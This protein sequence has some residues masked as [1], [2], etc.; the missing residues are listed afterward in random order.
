MMPHRKFSRMHT[1]FSM[2]LAR[3]VWLVSNEGSSKGE[4]C[5]CDADMLVAWDAGRR[6]VAVLAEFGV[7][8]SRGHCRPKIKSNSCTVTTAGF[9][10]ILRVPSKIIQQH[11]PHKQTRA[12]LEFGIDTAAVLAELGQADD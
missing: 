6:W 12:R 5:C 2:L 1:L 7:I 10:Q 9:M 11:I 3:S 8:C 4:A